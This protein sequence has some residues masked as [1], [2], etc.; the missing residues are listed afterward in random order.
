M[1]EKRHF[2]SS[3]RVVVNAPVRSVYVPPV[4]CSLDSVYG[5]HVLYCTSTCSWCMCECLARKTVHSRKLAHSGDSSH[6]RRFLPSFGMHVL[7]STNKI[8]PSLNNTCVQDLPNTVLKGH[9]KPNISVCTF[10]SIAGAHPCV[11]VIW[12]DLY[13]ITTLIQVSNEQICYRAKKWNDIENNVTLYLLAYL[14]FRLDSQVRAVIYAIFWK[15][16]KVPVDCKMF[17]SIISDLKGSLQ[18]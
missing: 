2:V 16:T 14:H 7:Y 3:G 4:S 1:S 15:M 18:I 8:S 12:S 5:P 9:L 13:H 17:L 6:R 10:H 11:S